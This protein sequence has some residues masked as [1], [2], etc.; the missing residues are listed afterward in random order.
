MRAFSICSI[1][2]RTALRTAA[3]NVGR[4]IRANSDKDT[5]TR[6]IFQGGRATSSRPAVGFPPRKPVLRGAFRTAAKPDSAQVAFPHPRVRVALAGFFLEAR[7]LARPRTR[8]SIRIPAATPARTQK[9][10]LPVGE[11]GHRS[12]YG[13]RRSE[14]PARIRVRSYSESFLRS[15][16]MAATAER[17]R[18]RT[19]RS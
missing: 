1:L 2:L 16:R 14:Q 11:G 4:T 17:P 18:N 3:E 6:A 15:T 8:E 12:G 9:S 10:P 19:S 7:V 5:G 13:P